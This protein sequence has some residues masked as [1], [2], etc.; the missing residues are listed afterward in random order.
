MC[1]RDS[2]SALATDDP[3]RTSLSNAMQAHA[4]AGLRYV[5]SGYYEGEHWLATFAVYHLTASG[6]ERR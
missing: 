4:A 6:L 2:T 3:R 5:F 1:I